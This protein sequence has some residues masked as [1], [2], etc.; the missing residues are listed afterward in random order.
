M[1]NLPGKPDLVF[2]RARVVIFCDGDFWHGRNWKR[3]RSSLAAGTNSEYWTS[4][5]ATNVKRDSR[6]TSL[7]EKSGWRVVRM[8]ETDILTN[9]SGTARLI[10]KIVVSR[11]DRELKGAGKRGRRD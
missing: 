4:K 3:L 2:R 7:L 1:K 9:A 8:W 10:K 11:L 5:I 6:I